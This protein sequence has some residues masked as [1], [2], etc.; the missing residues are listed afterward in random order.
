MT[1]VEDILDRR[2]FLSA[3]TQIV[4]TKI[5]QKKGYS[6][7]IDG[8]WGSGKT[9]ILDMLQ[10]RLKN[11]YL[12]VRY[13]CWKYD[14]YEEPLIALLSVFADAINSEQ[15][16]EY[17]DNEK[18]AKKIVGKIC[19]DTVSWLIKKGTQIDLKATVKYINTIREMMNE[20]RI[21]I[22][23]V[24]NK[25]PIEIIINQIQ[26][27]IATLITDGNR[28]VVL[29][30]DELDRCLPDYAIKVLERL[31]HLCDSTQIIQILAINGH[32][33]SGCVA[34]AYGYTNSDQDKV[35]S[36][37]RRYL[38]KFVDMVIPLNNGKVEDH[39]LQMLGGLEKSYVENEKTNEEFL[40]S[41]LGNILSDIP[42]R[43][44]HQVLKTVDAV[45]KLT[46]SDFPEDNQKYSYSLL[47]AEIL[48]CMQVV[49][50]KNSSELETEASNLNSI[51]I[52]LKVPVHS[53]ASEPR[54]SI[55]QNKV[56]H[57]FYQKTVF[58]NA[59]LVG[60]DYVYEFEWSSP[61]WYILYLFLNTHIDQVHFKGKIPECLN[62]DKE[63]FLAF[64]KKLQILRIR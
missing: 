60:R 18:K 14:F 26:S 56:E 21:K 6:F 8:E 54:H 55:F 33:L 47:C 9:T 34:K 23:E 13:N 62:K 46:L 53:Y 50:F 63:F 35:E 59:I 58:A 61:K 52:K 64:R 38:Q 31:H 29:M 11:K 44:L 40:S 22:K 27:D 32:S 20:K 10:Y 48:E 16:F 24:N 51:H 28:G 36:F 15:N 57:F 30:V 1:L 37:S 49:C 45:H 19:T 2:P 4:E 43:S 42:M 41:F 39:K 17:E 3:I 12:V 5:M 7:A 25:L